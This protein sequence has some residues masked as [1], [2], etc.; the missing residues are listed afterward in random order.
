[1]T[2]QPRIERLGGR[3]HLMSSSLVSWWARCLWPMNMLWW[4]WNP[5]RGFTVFWFPLCS[6][7]F[8]ITVATRADRNSLRKNSWFQKGWADMAELT[9]AG[10]PDHSGPGLEAGLSSE[11]R[12]TWPSSMRQAPL[13]SST[14]SQN[15]T[16]RWGMLNNQSLS[17]WDTYSTPGPKGS[18]GVSWDKMHLVLL[19]YFYFLF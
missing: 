2:V 4:G 17:L 8:R 6:S 13:S 10:S 12:L 3:A 7:C 14:P 9:A 18:L 1:M 19:F 11:A 15:S 16:T 5:G